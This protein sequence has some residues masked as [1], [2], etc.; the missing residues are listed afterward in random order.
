M[1]RRW[2]VPTA[3]IGGFTTTGIGTQQRLGVAPATASVAGALTAADFAKLASLQVPVSRL[4][5]AASTDLLSAAALAA[6][7]WVD[8]GTAQAFTASSSAAV[9]LVSVQAAVMVVTTTTTGGA[10]RLLN[11]LGGAVLL[12]GGSCAGAGRFTVSGGAFHSSGFAAGSHTWKLQVLANVA[13]TAYCRCNTEPNTEYVG[14]RIL[15]LNP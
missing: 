11:D 10:L 1:M 9:F 13:S 15:E 6:N 5:Y 8:V 7:T 12:G 3:T 2:V 14:I 4:T